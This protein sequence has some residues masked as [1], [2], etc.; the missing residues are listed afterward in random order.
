MCFIDAI[1]ACYIT[2]QVILFAYWK[3]YVTNYPMPY[4]LRNWLG[5]K[6]TLDEDFENVPSILLFGNLINFCFKIGED[7]SPSNIPLRTQ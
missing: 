2:W 1:Y 3:G 5:G 6:I 7:F 4:T